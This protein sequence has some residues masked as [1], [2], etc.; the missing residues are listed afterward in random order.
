MREGYNALKFYPL[1]EW[2]G[3]GLRHVTNRQVDRN[4]AKLAVEKVKVMREAVGPD[5]SI[6]ESAADPPK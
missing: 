3:G 4:F 6:L 1:A 2:D 5:M